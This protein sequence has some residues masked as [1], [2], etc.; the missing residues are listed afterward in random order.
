MKATI[1]PTTQA[2]QIRR[3]VE[4]IK[5][6]EQTIAKRERCGQCCESRNAELQRRRQELAEIKAALE[7]AGV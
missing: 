4:R 2:Q 6:L 5:R 3:N 7:E 1:G